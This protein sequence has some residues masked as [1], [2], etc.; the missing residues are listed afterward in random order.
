MFFFFMNLI[1][2]LIECSLFL[3]HIAILNFS[4]KMFFDDVILQIFSYVLL[5]DNLKLLRKLTDKALNDFMDKET[6]RF[7][8]KV[9]FDLRFFKLWLINSKF[10]N[11]LRFYS[12][13]HSCWVSS[14]I[15]FFFFQNRRWTNSRW[16]TTFDIL[17]SLKYS[18]RL[19]FN[20]IFNPLIHNII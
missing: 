14:N 5:I 13:N 8:L 4:A 12:S 17:K 11:R 15:S 6:R 16:C 19:N 2:N 9:V 1:F 10:I 3:N 18:N 20:G 7:L